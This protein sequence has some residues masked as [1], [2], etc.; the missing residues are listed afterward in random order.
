MMSNKEEFMDFCIKHNYTIM[1]TWFQKR[2]EQKITWRHPGTK[3]H[4]NKVRGHYAVKDYWLAT[5]RWK[6]GVTNCN[7]DHKHNINTD[8]YPLIIDIKVTLRAQKQSRKEPKEKYKECDD[9]Q[10]D[11][12][13]KDLKKEMTTLKEQKEKCY[14]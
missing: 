7:I 3:P 13:V 12:Y 4:H 5:K 10:N 6:N 1:N 9:E 2:A 8:H 11:E 14:A